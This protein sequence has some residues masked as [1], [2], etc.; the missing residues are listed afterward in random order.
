MPLLSVLVLLHAQY[1][2]IIAKLPMS[3]PTELMRTF[4]VLRRA[5]SW[6]FVSPAALDCM[7]A[8]PGIATRANKAGIG[9]L[10][11]LVMP[12]VMFLTVVATA[13]FGGG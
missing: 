12:V 2:S 5:W 11:V 9:G 10:I 8:E 13:W 6:V 1:L 3:W 4:S 7:L